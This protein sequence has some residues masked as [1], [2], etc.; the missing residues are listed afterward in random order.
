MF[1]ETADET[2][3]S[4]RLDTR[5]ARLG[6]TKLDFNNALSTYARTFGVD[7]ARTML[8]RHAGTVNYADVP[9]H[10]YGAIIAAI[11]KELVGAPRVK[12]PLEG[13]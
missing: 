10:R 7:S 12:R 6:W 4:G 11:A 3:R 1:F 8:Q 9:G 13:A 2:S 5:S